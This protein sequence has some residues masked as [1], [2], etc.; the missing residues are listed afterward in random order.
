MFHIS[1]SLPNGQ[2]DSFTSATAQDALN[3][4]NS[5]GL[6]DDAGFKTPGIRITDAAKVPLSIRDLYTL[7]GQQRA[8]LVSP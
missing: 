1:W 5:R 8:H 4:I 3:E 7:A 2:R 6:S